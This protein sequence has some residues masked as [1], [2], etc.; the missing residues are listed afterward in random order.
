M[1]RTGACS[2]TPGHSIPVQVVGTDPSMLHSL[3]RMVH[4]D[5]TFEGRKGMPASPRG[6]VRAA[7]T[8]EHLAGGKPAANPGESR[9]VIVS[10]RVPSPHDRSA[11]AGGLAVALADGVPP[12]SLWFG[13]SG[14]RSPDP[15]PPTVQVAGGISYAT[16]DLTPAE[17]QTYY[18]GFSNGALYPLL[19]HRI[20]LLRFRSDDYEGY[21]LVNARFAAV[22]TPL[23]RPGDRVWVHDYHLFTLPEE[24][25]ARGFAGP[26]GFFLHTPF[27]PAGL[28]TV[29]PRAAAL[30]RGICAADVVGFQ[31]A[32][33]RTNFAECAERL[34]GG[35][36]HGDDLLQVDGRT[37]RMVVTP[38]GID[39]D[40]FAATARAA[41]ADTAT[42]RLAESLGDRAL[43]FSVDRL[44][45][46]KGLPERVA[47]IGQFFDRHPHWR[48]RVN[49]LQVAAASRQDVGEY[50]RLRR[51]MDRLVGDL[52]GRMGEPDWTPLRYM[53]RPV[54]R[55]TLAGFHRLAR[56]GLVTPLRDGMNLVAKE[57][58]A[59]QDPENPGVLVLSAFAGAA[60][61]MEAAL[62]V[63]PFDGESVADALDAALRME[64]DERR[65][66]HRALLARVR[67]DTARR[68]CARFLAALAEVGRPAARATL[69]KHALPHPPSPRP[70][71]GQPAGLKD[72][73]A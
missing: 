38:V 42:C 55:T 5:R 40:G 44:D 9:L 25:R 2:G 63:N 60:E 18:Q 6:G 49:F 67:E 47:A 34:L 56:V 66:R 35:Q 7:M 48:R 12:G 19:L 36:R 30:L 29:L 4:R 10:N 33:D 70:A 16:T 61:S 41:T 52:N 14:K 43:V 39:A 8:D 24:L 20:G 64:L 31:T 11:Q 71:A 17:Y 51:E 72:A 32:H 65:A 46:T 54:R 62:V 26:I 53:T 27:A 59:A 1:F 37:L 57:F 21:R 23:L 3:S 15:A 22:L 45:Y 73:V 50:Q 68:F 28:I 58:V 13:W 69:M